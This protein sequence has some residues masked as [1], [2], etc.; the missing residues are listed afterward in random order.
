MDALNLPRTDPT[1][2]FEYFRGA[3]ATELLT[4][5]VAHLRVFE[6]LAP[7]SL[8]SDELMHLLKLSPRAFVVLF[9]ALR[10]MGLVARNASGQFE[11]TPQA[12]EHLV[13]GHEY[14][15]GGYIGLAASSPGVMSM[16]DR[17]TSNTLARAEKTDAGA[18]FIFREGLDSAMEQAESARRLTLALAG[19][20]KNVA[21]VLA[22][23][24]DIESGILL[25]VG[26]GTGIYAIAFLKRFPAL[27]AIVF[28]R[29][30][31]LKVAAEFAESYG[32][33][34][35]IELRP[36]DMFSNPL[37]SADAVLLS[38]VLHDWDV[39]ECKALVHRCAD[40]L[41]SGGQLLIHDVF[42]N[43][44]HDGPLPVA[45]YSASLF[46]LTEGRAYSAAEYREWISDAGLL[47]GE[48]IPT[49][50]HCGVQAGTK[51]R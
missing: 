3:H 34:D 40:A 16:L 37:P 46:S 23:K 26:G 25:D 17:L 45:L 9:T 41:N 32:V 11:L 13:P 51:R 22:Q 30:E 6:L 44:D 48:V 7:H 50:V 4:V 19:R 15:V 8:S 47:P 10:A 21:P 31:V 38:N 28:D 1:S 27:R 35:R 43:D 24:I 18:A 36:G 39:P 14:F 20:A 5:A 29:P 49:L 42:L 33:A 2:I 12:R